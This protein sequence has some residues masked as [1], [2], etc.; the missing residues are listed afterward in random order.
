MEWRKRKKS[1]DKMIHPTSRLCLE[2]KV[3]SEVAISTL[4]PNVG[5]CGMDVDG[6]R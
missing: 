1:L 2:R 6:D 5:R 3:E 4:A